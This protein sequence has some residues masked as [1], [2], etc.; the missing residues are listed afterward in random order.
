[1]EAVRRE[2]ARRWFGTIA[3]APAGFLAKSAHRLAT[4]RRAVIE[5]PIAA[6]EDAS[7]RAAFLHRFRRLA[8]DLQVAGVLLRIDG[9]PGGWA[10][11]QDLRQAILGLRRAR[12]RVHAA[13]SSPGNAAMAIAS[14]CDRVFLAPLDEVGLVGIGAELTF[15]GGALELIFL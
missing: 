6:M 5:V 4:G 1:M 13:L 3:S 14:A 9:P 11:T 15:F 12:K 2:G 10:P 8:E 7:T